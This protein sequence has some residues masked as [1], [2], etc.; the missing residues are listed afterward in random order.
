MSNADNG[1][2]ESAQSLGKASLGVSIAGIIIAVV[3]AV[4]LI[5]LQLV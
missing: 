5:I 1:D 4:I 2:V 3:G